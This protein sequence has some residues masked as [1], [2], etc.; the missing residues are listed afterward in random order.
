VGGSARIDATVSATLDCPAGADCAL[1]GNVTAPVQITPTL[2]APSLANLQFEPSVNLFGFVKLEAGN[3]FL[4]Q[5][6]FEALEAKAGAELGASLTLEAVQIDNADPDAGRSKYALA[7]KGEVGPG[8]K[9]GEFFEYVGLARAVPL[10]LAFSH[11][12]G[13]SPAAASVSADR[14]SYL[15]GERVTLNV[16]LAPDSVRFPTGGLYNVERVVV[17]RR[18]GILETQRLAEVV[19]TVEGQTEF[20]LSFDAPGPLTARELFV[21]VATSVLPLDPPLLELAVANAF[22]I[23]APGARNAVR[24]QPFEAALQALGGQAPL[25]W[26]AVGL[27]PGL[28]IGAATGVLNGSASQSGVYPVQV[29]ARSADGR[30]AS[31]E[32]QLTVTEFPLVEGAYWGTN[33]ILTPWDPNIGRSGP[34]GTSL[35]QSPSGQR[36]LAV[37]DGW[38]FDIAADGTLTFLGFDGGDQDFELELGIPNGFSITGSI[39]ADRLTLLISLPAP[40]GYPNYLFRW[41]LVRQ[42]Q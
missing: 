13:T 39:V 17:Q 33:T 8:L 18:T 29:S 28:Q 9:L 7:F 36:V 3:A 12:L 26:S 35:R 1:S 22:D 11:D 25:S 42:P 14:A 23:V 31:V 6:Q 40:G 24:G 16:R 37:F 38:L 2:R 41:D 4:E 5:L 32:F 20:T 30:S 27:P 15:Q 10:K 34:K 19:P 21:F